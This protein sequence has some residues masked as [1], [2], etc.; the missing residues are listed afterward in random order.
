VSFFE[1]LDEGRIGVALPDEE[2][3][4]VLFFLAGGEESGEGENDNESHKS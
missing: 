2:A 4:R 1:G 3:K